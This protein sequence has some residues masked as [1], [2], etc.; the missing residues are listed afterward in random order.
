MSDESSE[1]RPENN[2]ERNSESRQSDSLTVERS[3]EMPLSEPL[4][5]RLLALHKGLLRLHKVLLDD[6]QK[7]Y[8]LVHGQ[9]PGKGQLLNLVMY[10]PW[11]EWL[12]RISESIIK[13]DETLE[14]EKAS[15]LDASE[16]MNRFRELFRDGAE[17]ETEF[18]RRYRVVMQREPA[19]I[20]AHIEVQK[21]LLSDA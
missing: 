18:M 7:A 21:L 11:F 14:D 20:L 3:I 10:D 17:G 4:R 6:E 12:H 13:I 1:N 19:A 16:L 9:V 15:A 2:S 8:E 5:Q